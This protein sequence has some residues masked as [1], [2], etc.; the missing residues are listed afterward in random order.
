[1]SLLIWCILISVQFI[2]CARINKP[3][4]QERQ[5]LEGLLLDAIRTQ[6]PDTLD[7]V[8]SSRLDSDGSVVTTINATNDNFF[9]YF[10]FSSNR[11][12]PQSQVNQQIWDIGIKRYKF[13]TNSGA[14]NSKGQGGACL[15]NQVSLNQAASLSPQNQNCGN[16]FFQIDSDSQTQGIGGTLGSFIGNPLLTDWFNYR[17]GELN[18]KNQVYLVRSGDGNS[19]FAFRMEGYYSQAGTS[20]YP[21]FRWRK[22]Q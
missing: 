9:V 16:N 1:M 17:I 2:S 20:G 10:S 12:I 13:S 11:Q 14:T 15:S 18:P 22:L 8:I 4:S 21:N 6:N 19:F 3:I 7:K 5:Y